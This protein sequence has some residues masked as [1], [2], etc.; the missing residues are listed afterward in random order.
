MPRAESPEVRAESPE[1]ARS[2]ELNECR[3]RRAR[4]WHGAV[5]SAN[6]ASGEPGGGTEHVSSP[7]AASGEPGGGTEHA[8]QGLRSRAGQAQADVA[9]NQ[10]ATA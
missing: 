10:R 6:A 7:N 5:S 1:V 8:E 2:G 3:E 9:I 4:S